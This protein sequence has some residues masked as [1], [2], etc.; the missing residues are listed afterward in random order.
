M[1]QACNFSTRETV[2]EE[3]SEFKAILADL[4]SARLA[5]TI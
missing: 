1:A 2:G 4:A 5:I 3:G